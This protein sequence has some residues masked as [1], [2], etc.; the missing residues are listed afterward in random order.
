MTVYCLYHTPSGASRIIP[1]QFAADTGPWHPITVDPN[2]ILSDTQTP[3]LTDWHCTPTMG[4]STILKGF[5]EIDA[6]KS[7][8]QH[9]TLAAGDALIVL[10]TN[11]GPNVEGHKGHSHGPDGVSVLMLKLSAA[12]I[13]ALAASFTNWPTDLV[14]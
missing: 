4:I 14:L 7:D 3:R 2:A 13:P 1:L 6:N 12:D 10:D 9:V 8:P 11:S 5:L